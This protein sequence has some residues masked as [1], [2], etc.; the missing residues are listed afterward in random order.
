MPHHYLHSRKWK[1]PGVDIFNSKYPIIIYI[2][3]NAKRPG[4]D[5]L[6]SK[7]LIIIYIQENG[8]VKV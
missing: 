4:V 1:R 6:N 7:C 2:Q 8:K 3:E 5:I